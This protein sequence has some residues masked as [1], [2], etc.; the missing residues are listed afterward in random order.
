MQDTGPVLQ[1]LQMEAYRAVLRAMAVAPMQY[2][3]EKL[4]T[5][6][7]KELNVGLDKHAA[8]LQE[9]DNDQEVNSIREALS[10]QR[11]EQASGAPIPV[12]LDIPLQRGPGRPTV[13]R[14]EM[15]SYGA[16]AT[17][18]RPGSAGRTVGG[19]TAGGKAKRSK[20]PLAQLVEVDISGAP[21]MPQRAPVAQDASV[22]PFIGRYIQR[23]WPKEGRKWHEGIITDYDPAQGHCI[24]YNKDAKGEAWEWVNFDKLRLG[25]ETSNG[26][27]WVDKPGGAVMGDQA[28]HRRNV[29][30]GGKRKRAEPECPRLEFDGQA[31]YAPFHE[32]AFKQRLTQAAPY[33]LDLMQQVLDWREGEIHNEIRLLDAVE[34]GSQ[35]KSQPMKLCYLPC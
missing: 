21:V 27:R 9:L 17:Q 25:A 5:S 19:M 7:R 11:D 33:E 22:D 10:S 1:R 35:G 18:G 32:A 12:D 6:L 3:Q 30:P 15:A 26:Y 14:P 4:L 2:E 8:V 29:G 24:T 31:A 23:F 20:Q 34:D 28:E 13:K 16:P